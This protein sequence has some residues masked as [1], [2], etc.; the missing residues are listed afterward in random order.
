M[1][2]DEAKSLMRQELE[3]DIAPEEREKKLFPIKDRVMSANDLMAEV[4]A[5][6]E[7]GQYLLDDFISFKNGG[8]Q[9]ED[10]TAMEKLGIIRL[11]EEDLKIAPAGWADEVIFRDGDQR[12]T[13]NK[14]MSEVRAETKFGLRYMK[15]YYTNHKLLEGLLGKDY[16]TEPETTS[17][18]F[19]IPK[20][21]RPG[22]D[23]AN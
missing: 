2:R 16:L 9:E 3:Q 23:Q 18:L 6:T 10:L 11:M 22:D 21:K 4:E 17:D 1:T 7:L 8:E 14:I 19:S 15:V 13:P 5:E 20:G 12:W